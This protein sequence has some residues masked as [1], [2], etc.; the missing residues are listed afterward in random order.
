VAAR[1]LLVGE[2]DAAGDLM[3]YAPDAQQ[4]HYELSTLPDVSTHAV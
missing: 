4:F 2:N 3:N 1:I